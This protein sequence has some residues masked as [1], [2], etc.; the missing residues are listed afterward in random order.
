VQ[1]ITGV[2]PE[3]ASDPIIAIDDAKVQEWESQLQTAKGQQLR[4]RVYTEFKAA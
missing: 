4:D 1:E 2:D 3:L